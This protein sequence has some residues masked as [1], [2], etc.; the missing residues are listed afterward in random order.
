MPIPHVDPY[1]PPQTP[2]DYA[3]AER[4][5]IISMQNIH[6]GI[7][8]PLQGAK[9][10]LSTEM[11]A[12]RSGWAG[13][14]GTNVFAQTARSGLGALRESALSLFTPKQPSEMVEARD[15]IADS[16]D[17][18]KLLKNV[19]NSLIRLEKLQEK[20]LD[21]P[22]EVVGVDTEATASKLPL[23]GKN[24][25]SQ[26]EQKFEVTPVEDEGIKLLK[27]Q[28][29]EAEKFSETLKRKLVSTE[30]E[31]GSI[32]G[33]HA[34][35]VTAT[36]SA[37]MQHGIFNSMGS[38]IFTQ[39][40]MAG[41]G[42]LGDTLE[43]V[44]AK[45]TSKM[46]QPKQPTESPIETPKEQAE[47]PKVDE[48]DI[49]AYKRRGKKEPEFKDVN[50]APEKDDYDIPAYMR[51]GKKDAQD[52]EFREVNSEEVVDAVKKNSDVSSSMLDELV[53]M[54]AYYTRNEKLT[55]AKAAEAKAMHVS[56]PG[57]NPLLEKAKAAEETPSGGIFDKLSEYAGMGAA[58]LGAGALMGGGKKAP[59]APG[60]PNGKTPGRFGN[61]GKL[62][63]RGIGGAVAGLATGFAVDKLTEAGYNKTAAG[64]DVLGNAA[65]GAMMG[66]IFGPVGTIVGGI[67]GA[68]YGAY[69]QW[70][71][72]KTEDPAEQLAKDADE[73]NNR[74][75]GSGDA[76]T[77]V[78]NS[79][80]TNVTNN[81][82]VMAI[83][84][85][86]R[87]EDFTLQRYLTWQGT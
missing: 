61:V 40:L 6:T 36:M 3:Y 25:R 27:Q 76:S 44:V 74:N 14:M 41:L 48:T 32:V 5:K 78:I 81:E 1:A 54:N 66:S 16:I 72:T 73:L 7:Q 21:K 30:E 37:G 65:A 63:G 49:P 42:A 4:Q 59:D 23:H 39:T 46:G 79:N 38:N 75:G 85:P 20:I 64:V 18:S 60:K 31:Q 70:Q 28:R 9:Q 68:A 67:G 80:N 50:A 2:M 10:T 22:V 12:I 51:R 34:S 77:N 11:Q 33:A 84:K 24:R 15:D 56:A 8:G 52:V 83:R 13:S 45:Q 19:L 87:N 17:N 53:K 71:K 47:A 43:Q 35:N 58:A 29:E 82:T 57:S 69:N 55:D 86:V 26:K 62:L